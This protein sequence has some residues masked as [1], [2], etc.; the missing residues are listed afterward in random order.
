MFGHAMLKE[1][2]RYTIRIRKAHTKHCYAPHRRT[3]L[4]NVGTVRRGEGRRNCSG[5]QPGVGSASWQACCVRGD[6]KR[7]RVYVGRRITARRT[8]VSHGGV[9]WWR[10]REGGL[11]RLEGVGERERR[12]AVVE[13]REAGEVAFIRW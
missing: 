7:R 13:V 9:H 12:W 4:D 3:L 11:T 1:E 5:S 2:E 6:V 10:G 8:G